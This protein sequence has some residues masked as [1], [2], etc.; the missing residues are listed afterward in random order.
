MRRRGGRASALANFARPLVQAI[1]ATAKSRAVIAV[2]FTD[3]NRA[4]EGAVKWQ[5]LRSLFLSHMV[6]GTSSKRHCDHSRGPL[7]TS[8]FVSLVI[9]ALDGKKLYM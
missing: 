2:S 6:H 5:V 3:E 4:A 7:L 9:L 1:S 8:P